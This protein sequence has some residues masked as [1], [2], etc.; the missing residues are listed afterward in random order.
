[1]HLT[2]KSSVNSL[3]PKDYTPVES[4]LSGGKGKWL[5]F[6][7]SINAIFFHA[8]FIDDFVDDETVKFDLV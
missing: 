6:A 4:L 7:F 3:I 1:M 2:P 8:I 5:H